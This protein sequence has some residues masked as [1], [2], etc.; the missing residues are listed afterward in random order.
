MAFA[1]F[2]PYNV[3]EARQKK[4]MSVVN[5][6]VYI[7][8]SDSFELTYLYKPGIQK[9]RI[10]VEPKKGNSY[11]YIYD[12]DKL[13]KID[14]KL[15][16]KEEVSFL[17]LPNLWV[18]EWLMFIPEDSRWIE[19]NEGISV[20]GYDRENAHILINV[21]KTGK[22]KKVKIN[23]EFRNLEIEYSEYFN[24]GDFN[25]YPSKWRVSEEGKIREF[26]VEKVYLNRG[27]CTPC[28]FQLSKFE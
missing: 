19:N 26:S 1:E 6:L 13:W 3:I 25:G 15:K 21:D 28:Q 9:Y 5:D 27:F 11:F 2:N 18:H 14:K 24:L 20:M 16:L 8:E 12:S 23:S 22:I 4:F 10:N 17:E 7:V